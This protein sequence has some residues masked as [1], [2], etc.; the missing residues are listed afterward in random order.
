MNDSGAAYDAT[1][2]IY[3]YTMRPEVQC[4]MD[5]AGEFA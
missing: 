4:A 1:R 3:D 5:R 2:G